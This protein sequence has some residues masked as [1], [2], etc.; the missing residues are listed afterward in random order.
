MAPKKWTLAEFL[1]RDIRAAAWTVRSR[2][3]GH[4][5]RLVFLYWV[6][7][8]VPLRPEP[9]AAAPSDGESMDEL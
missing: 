5:H 9:A 3:L 6:R 8:M 2:V 1:D 4:W 7:H